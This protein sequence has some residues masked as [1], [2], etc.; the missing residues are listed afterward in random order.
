MVTR[1]A[2]VIPALVGIMAA[3]VL[4]AVEAFAKVDLRSTFPGRRVGGGTRGECSARLLA[5]LVPES[6][7]YAPGSPATLAVLEGPTANPYSLMVSFRPQAGG[8]A[9]S[10]TLPASAAGV[11]LLQLP[12]LQ[13]AT[14]WESSYRC[15]DGQP[16]SD[17]PLGF[18][19]AS[20]RPALS[21]LVADR[22]PADRT[23]EAS[24]Q[25]LRRQCGQSVPKQQ[26]ARD[27]GLDELKTAEWPDQLPVRCLF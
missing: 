14:V 27:F 19:S 7:V 11:T 10:R 1:S 2:P 23:V 12:P 8:A 16:V 18:V 5:H 17:D 9:V 21:L 13:A 20:S 24:L 25:A 22:T 26:L 4:L 15:E 6:S 3:T